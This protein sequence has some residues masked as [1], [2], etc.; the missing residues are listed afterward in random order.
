[1]ER[2]SSQVGMRRS[3][4]QWLRSS[5]ERPRFSEPNKRAARL[6]ARRLR[7]R[8]AACSRRLTGC[9]GSRRPTAVVPT[10]RVQSATASARLLNSSARARRGEAPTAERA[11]RK[12]KSY[13]ATTRRWKKPKLLMARAAAPMLRGLRGLTRTTHKRSSSEYGDKGDEFTAGEKQRSNEE[14]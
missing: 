14:R 7:I 12:A 6:L 2:W 10:T 4:W 3:Q 13:G 9:C 1:M 5:L 11:S 8:G